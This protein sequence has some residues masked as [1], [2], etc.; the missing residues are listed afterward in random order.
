YEALKRDRG[1]IDFGDLISMPVRLCEK[2]FEVRQ[3]LTTLYQHVLVD[4]YQDVNR[5]SVRLLEAITDSGQNLWAVGDAKQSV[6]RFR[7]ASSFNVAR[8]GS[9][10]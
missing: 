7:G 9:D 10:D 3:H 2:E 1:C 8:F 6:Y 4:E 5:A